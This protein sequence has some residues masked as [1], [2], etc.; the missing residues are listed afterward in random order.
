MEIIFDNIIFSLQKVGGISIVWQNL[1]KRLL[2][3]HLDIRFI[4]YK[5]SIENIFRNELNI[6]DELI[7]SRPFYKRLTQFFSP[8]IKYENKFIFHSSYFRTC[9]SPNAI[10]VTTVHDFIYEQGNMTLPQRIRT[11]LDYRA[12]RKSDAV[13]CISENTKN[14][15]LKYIPNIDPCKI[16]VIYNGVSDEYQHLDKAPYP[17][18]SDYVLFVGGRKGYKNFEFTVKALRKTKY[19]LL[20]CGTPLSNSEKQLLDYNLKNRYIIIEYP[21]NEE[22]N[23]IYN[24]VFCLLYPSSYEGFGLP[25]VEAQRAGCPVIALNRSSIPEI[26]GDEALLMPELSSYWLST[27]LDQLEN[28]WARLKIVED[29]IVKSFSFSWDKMAN[30]YINLYT[31]LL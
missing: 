27:M 16:H 10:N 26:V 28:K 9:N 23:K 6:P 11:W 29:G 3:Q 18:Y 14:D 5:N 1:I 24:S 7:I 30:D 22:L 13:V 19:K 25:V 17:K 4:E 12:I 20:I 31:S 21:S 8:T 15:L 2:T